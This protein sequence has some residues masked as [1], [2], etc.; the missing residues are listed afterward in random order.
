MRVNVTKL[1]GCSPEVHALQF[2]NRL[3]FVCCEHGFSSSMR[4]WYHF[5]A[6]FHRPLLQLVDILNT[7]FNILSVQLTIITAT[8]ELF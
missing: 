2:A 5:P 4:Q 8:V 1:I 6:D 3:Q 7:L